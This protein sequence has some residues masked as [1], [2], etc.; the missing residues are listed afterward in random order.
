VLDL[1]SIRRYQ[2][3]KVAIQATKADRDNTRG[4]GGHQVAK[5]Y[6]AALR[7]G[8]DAETAQSN[9]E[10]S[11]ALLKQAD[12]LKA[13]GT[14]TGIEVTVPA[15]NS[16]TTSSGSYFLITRTGGPTCNYLKR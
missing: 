13:A 6:L 4:P 8:T 16:P 9:V 1:S 7:A 12:N 15:F 10:L 14:G 11:E 2:A 5:A 3:S